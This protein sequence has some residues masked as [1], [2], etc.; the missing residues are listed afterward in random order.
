MQEHALGALRSLAVDGSNAAYDFASIQLVYDAIFE[1]FSMLPIAA[2]VQ[3]K[4]LVIHGGLGDGT[5]GLSELQNNIPRPLVYDSGAGIP[6][7]IHHALWSDPSESDAD[8]MRGVH[9]GGG[10]HR[11]VRF[12]PDVTKQFCRANNIDLVV[13]SHQL[14]RK[15]YKIMHSGH[16]ISVFS[17]R[18]YVGLE[19]NDGAL[20]LLALDEQGC[21][22]VRPKTL[23]RLIS[24]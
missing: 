8:M 14:M 2:L 1:A 23:R 24:S 11:V 17:A 9:H 16:L 18:N 7:F 10:Q 21:L 6:P 15:G 13:R 19:N 4:V 12:G 22:R 3:N 5:W 20:L